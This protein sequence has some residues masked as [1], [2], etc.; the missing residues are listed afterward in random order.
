MVFNSTL[1]I[2]YDSNDVVTTWKYCS[3]PPIRLNCWKDTGKRLGIYY[4]LN[5]F[6]NAKLHFLA[7]AIIKRHKQDDYEKCQMPSKCYKKK[8][9]KLK[10]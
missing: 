1:N 3:F 7:G 5:G 6:H 9:L 4:L 8:E 10:Y 2:I